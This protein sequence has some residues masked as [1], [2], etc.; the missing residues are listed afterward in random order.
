MRATSPQKSPQFREHIR[1]ATAA[2]IAPE[3]VPQ[4]RT[5]AATLTARSSASGPPSRRKAGSRGSSMQH[6]TEGPKKLCAENSGEL[7]PPL[8]TATEFARASQ[9]TMRRSEYEV[10]STESCA[11]AYCEALSAAVGRFA[12]RLSSPFADCQFVEEQTLTKF[13]LR[14][15]RMSAEQT[16]GTIMRASRFLTATTRA[17]AV[18]GLASCASMGGGGRRYAL[19]DR[20]LGLE[21]LVSI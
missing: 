4:C 13:A 20:S 16:P 8:P 2:A 17:Y 10:P 14:A 5:S 12:G 11:T 1:P 19:P 18:G 3:K 15:S 9:C 7:L 21:Q 6:E